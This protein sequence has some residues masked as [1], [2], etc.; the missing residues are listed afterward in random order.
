MLSDLPD[1]FLRVPGDDSGGHGIHLGKDAPDFRDSVLVD[2]FH[3]QERIVQTNP[4]LS[5]Q[6][7][8]VAPSSLN[9]PAISCPTL[10]LP[11]GPRCP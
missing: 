10:P 6:S 2:L 5:I 9:A 1:H 8:R 7:L 3:H 4:D 11:L